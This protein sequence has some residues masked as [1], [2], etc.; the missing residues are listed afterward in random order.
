M[1]K[2]LCG[3]AAAAAFLVVPAN[4]ALAATSPSDSVSRGN[5][6]GQVAGLFG[7]GGDVGVSDDPV[8]P[9]TLY[10]VV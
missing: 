2:S 4:P 9:F 8:D 6:V 7:G 3:M 10:G 1:A 5:L